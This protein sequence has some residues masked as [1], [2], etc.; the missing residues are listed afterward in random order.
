MQENYKHAAMAVTYINFNGMMVGEIRSGVTTDYLSDNQG[1]AWILRV[2]LL[3]NACGA[4]IGPYEQH[5]RLWFRVELN[6]AC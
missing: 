2:Q 5:A 4:K 1:H 6:I 3:E